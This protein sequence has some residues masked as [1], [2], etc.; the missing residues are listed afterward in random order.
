M[1]TRLFVQRAG[2]EGVPL[3]LQRRGQELVHGD[4]GP[5]EGQAAH[6]IAQVV[7]PPDPAAQQLISASRPRVSGCQI[8]KDQDAPGPRS[9]AHS[10]WCWHR[11]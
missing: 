1:P 5:V 10:T 2:V 11:S 3:R 9:Q 7:L 6:A 4:G 8:L